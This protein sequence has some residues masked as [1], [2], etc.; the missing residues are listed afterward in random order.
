MEALPNKVFD[1]ELGSILIRKL[2]EKDEEGGY[3]ALDTTS[4]RETCEKEYRIP[5][6]QRYN[7]WTLEAK[8]NTIDSIWRNYIIGSL[9]L[10]RQSDGNLGWFLD[11]EDGQSRLTVIQEYL[12]D[13]FEYRGGKFSDRTQLEQDR[14]LD[15]EF[16]TDITQPSRIRP[17][18]VLDPMTTEDHRFE[19]FDRINKGK[20]L[21]DNDKYWALKHKPMVARAIE[22]IEGCKEDYPF[23]K[24]DKFNTKDK[25]GKVIRKP[26]DQIV[27]LIDAL[28]NDA[29][30]KSYLRHSENMCKPWTPSHEERLNQ[31][32]IFYKS[33]YN[34][35]IDKRPR[36]SGEQ[37]PFNNPGKFLGMIIMHF[38]QSEEDS[39]MS[40][41]EKS[42]LWVN[43]LNID[44]RSYNFMGGTATLWMGFTS[45]DQ[46]NQEETNI[47]KR[48][49]RVKEF[50]ENK[51]ETARVHH[52]EFIEP[53]T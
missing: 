22:L 31:F 32:M 40:L 36:N 25:N 29:Y 19:N 43:I 3:V 30:K 16:S 26:L 48:L 15:Y 12:D 23:M 47:L 35:M 13:K 39:G 50:Y 27:T 34:G 45:G 53:V 2:F 46:K 51:E 33:I 37:I 17:T 4:D 7:K 49:N 38:K 28:I 18:T 21:E 9:S 14:F 5:E 44:R 52:I 6:H 20:A 24:T 8:E 1:R 10:S 41:D 11:I 42:E